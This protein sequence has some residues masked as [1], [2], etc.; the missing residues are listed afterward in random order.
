MVRYE[1][2]NLR[3]VNF[4]LPGLLGQGVAA[5]TRF[6]PQAKALGEW[7]RS[8]HVPRSSR[9]VDS[10]EMERHCGRLV[11]RF[12]EREIVPHLADWERAG[13]VPRVVAQDGRRPGPPRRPVPELRRRGRHLLD[14]ATISE[15]IILAGGSSGLI[16]ALFTHGIAL[17]H[18]LAAGDPALIERYVKPTITGRRSA[19]SA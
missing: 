14:T 17:P 16:A 18:I 19:R 1:L 11:R 6:D 7:L 5:S 2:P 15:E 10:L 12:T 13:E 4:V 9:R 8:R 3:A